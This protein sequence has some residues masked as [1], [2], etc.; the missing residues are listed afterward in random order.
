MLASLLVSEVEA[1]YLLSHLVFHPSR[2]NLDCS[3][4]QVWALWPLFGEECHSRL[5]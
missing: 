1:L 2:N 5:D 4:F 3:F